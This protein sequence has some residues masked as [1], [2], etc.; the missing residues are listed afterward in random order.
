MAQAFFDAPHSVAVTP[1]GTTY[2]VDTLHH[3]IQ[4]FD[5]R[6]QFIASIGKPGRIW[7]GTFH[8]PSDIGISTSGDL[9]VADSYNHRIQKFNAQGKFLKTI[10]GLF[11]IGI[12]LSWKCFFNV[13]ISVYIDSFE[14]MYVVD[15]YNHR[16]Q[17][18]DAQGKFITQFGSN[19]LKH[20][21][22]MALDHNGNVWVV[23][24][25]HNRL[26]LF[27]KKDNEQKS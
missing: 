1:Q 22:D 10:G 18:F 16:I 14:N 9:Y 8:Y 23:D 17:K 6:G 26:V 20:P 2:V 12:P 24:Y 5:S 25:G 11:G 15:F 4:K 3:R 19:I 7:G 21:T 13:A 27:R